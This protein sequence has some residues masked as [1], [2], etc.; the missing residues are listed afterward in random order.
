MNTDVYGCVVDRKKEERRQ[1]D[2][3]KQRFE[4]EYG[5]AY[6]AAAMY[7]AERESSRGGGSHANS[8]YSAGADYSEYIRSPYTKYSNHADHQAV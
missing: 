4:L 2:K 3:Q 1:R 6:S 7:R 8:A 5:R